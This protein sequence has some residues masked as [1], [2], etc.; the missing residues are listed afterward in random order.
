MSVPIFQKGEIFQLKGIRNI[1]GSLSDVDLES[2]KNT[3]FKFLGTHKTETEP[4]TYGQLNKLNEKIKKSC[5][6]KNISISSGGI[7][8]DGNVLRLHLLKDGKLFES[9]LYIHH[10]IDIENKVKITKIIH[11]IVKEI[12]YFMKQK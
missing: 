4:F 11:Q 12:E 10:N 8:D 9:D 7:Y 5:Q 6:Y 3:F 2:Y 1:I